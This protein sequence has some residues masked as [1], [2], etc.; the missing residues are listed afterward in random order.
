MDIL[1]SPAVYRRICA[2]C[3]RLRLPLCIGTSAAALAARQRLH[4]VDDGV[5]ADRIAQAGPIL[6][7]PAVDEG[8]HVLAQ[9]AAVV[10]HVAARGAVRARNTTRGRRR[11]WRP[12][13]PR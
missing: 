11:A 3:R 5:G 13:P 9:P 7:L 2:I 1:P 4:D 6:N 12:P 10:Q 8:C